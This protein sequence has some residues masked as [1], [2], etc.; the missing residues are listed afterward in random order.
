MN[1][2]EVREG[3][4]NA[5]TRLNDAHTQADG[6]AL[7]EDEQ[8]Q[9]DEDM[10]YIAEQE[11]VL[12][13]YDEIRTLAARGYVEAPTPDPI[14][15][16]DGLRTPGRQN[17]WD[18]N[19]VTR[20]LHQETP[21]KGGQ[22][23]RSRALDAVE[24]SVGINDRSKEHITKLLSA[25]DMEDDEAEGS[26]ARRLAAHVIATSSPEYIRAWSKAFKTGMRTGAPDMRALDVLQR[27]MSLTDASGG[28]AVPLP[29]DPTLILDDDQTV[30]PF[31]QISTVKTIVTDELKTVNTTAVTASYDAEAAEV[32]D[33]A[34]TFANTN[35]SMHMA[36]AFVPHSIEIGMDYPGFTQDI[37]FLLA[38]AKMQLEDAKFATGSGTG[39]PFGVVT[40][41]TGA[42]IIASN[43]ADTFALG[44]VY[45]LDEELPS[46]FARNAAWV[47]NKKIYTAIR[48]AGNANLD[49]FWVNLRDGQPS[50]LLGHPTYEASEMDGVIDAA[51]DNKVLILGDFKWYWIV[52]RVGF[53]MELVPHLFHT[54]TNRPSG[55]RGV[56]AYWRNGADVVLER[57]FRLLNVT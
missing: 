19:V 29:I 26:G 49:D 46:R 32:S 50:Q 52:D 53:S 43:T 40:G 41:I 8:R 44:D 57:A 4:E 45:D 21:E 51:A 31:R 11:R 38:D 3:L 30:S 1:E 35:I 34:T 23:L 36:R 39:E 18:L 20:A 7:T 5:R 24:K 42:N 48:E 55:Q 6:R 9:W 33:D 13:R 17:P 2:Q 10:A 56:F 54:T 25:F 37:A 27:A 47:A 16:P 12:A 15:E 14:A 28:H 22:E